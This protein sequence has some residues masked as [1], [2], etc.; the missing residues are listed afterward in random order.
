MGLSSF[1]SEIPTIIPLLL[2]TGHATALL[3]PGPPRAPKSM[4]CGPA[5]HKAACET[6]SPC[7]LADPETQPRSLMPLPPPFNPPSVSSGTIMYLVC[8][9][10]EGRRTGAI[11]NAASKAIPAMH[12]DIL[13]LILPPHW[14]F[15][16]GP[17]AEMPVPVQLRAWL[18]RGFRQD[19]PTASVYKP[20]TA[21]QNRTTGRR[22]LDVFGREILGRAGPCA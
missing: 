12:V 21:R 8:G 19:E 17:G 11:A 3:M 5:S 15:V 2:L 22:R 6:L 16:R 1:V 4:T 18:M 20:W 14:F 13:K 10:C 7:W 9:V